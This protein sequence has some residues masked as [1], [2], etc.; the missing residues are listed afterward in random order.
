MTGR[1]RVL[2]A[3]AHGQADRIPIDFWAVGAVF[4]RLVT[5]LKADGTEGVLRRF[6]VDVRYFLG[7]GYVAPNVPDSSDETFEDHWGVRRKWHTVTGTR[8]DDKPYTWTYK[9]MVHS[10]LAGAQTVADIE[11]HAWPKPDQW[12][13]SQVKAC[14]EAIRKTGA[15]VIFGGDRL[16]RT[17]QLKAAMYLRGTEQFM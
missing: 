12:D 6:D 3:V 4:D 10:P 16:D 8:A 15:A 7:P 14:C 5:E 13:F 2:Q 1:Q 9:H 17:A 11:R